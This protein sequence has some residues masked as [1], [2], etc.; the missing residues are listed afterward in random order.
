MIY[1]IAVIP[2]ISLIKNKCYNYANAV[3]I[4][5]EKPIF[6]HKILFYCFISPCYISAFDRFWSLFYSETKYPIFAFFKK[7]IRGS[8]ISC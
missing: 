1:G 7:K 8:I 6:N 4:I 3:L 2:D 5:Y